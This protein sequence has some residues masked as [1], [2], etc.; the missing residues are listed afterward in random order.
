MALILIIMRTNLSINITVLQNIDF[1]DYNFVFGTVL[2][3]FS[4]IQFIFEV[5]RSFSTSF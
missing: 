3:G 1:A 4:N 5:G 2:I